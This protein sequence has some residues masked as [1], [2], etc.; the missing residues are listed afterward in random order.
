VFTGFAV[1][2]KKEVFLIV[3]RERDFLHCE[4]GKRFC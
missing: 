1:R 2:E 3:R 4:E